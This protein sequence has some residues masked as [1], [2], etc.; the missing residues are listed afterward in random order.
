MILRWPDCVNVR[1]LGGL[2][3]TDGLVTRPGALVRA[4]SLSRLTAEGWHAL[5]EHGIRTI[6]DLR[7][8]DER[9]PDAAPRPADV[10]TVHLPHDSMHDR[11]FWDVWQTGPQFASPLYYEP[12]LERFPDVNAEVVRAIAHARPGGVVVHCAAGRDRTG[13][14]TAVVLALLGVI[15]RAIAEDYARSP[16]EEGVD[17]H[18]AARGTSSAALI[19]RLARRDLQ[20]DLALRDDDVAALRERLLTSRACA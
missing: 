6:V 11:E 9:P 14:V 1:D 20:G 8:H 5:R 7:N 15:P 18:L 16:A 13:M 17:D 10:E 4:G 3:T 19:E 12:H 2:H